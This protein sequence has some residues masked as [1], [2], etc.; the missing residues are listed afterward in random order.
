[1]D[2]WQS[3]IFPNLRF[4]EQ[5]TCE[6]NRKSY[7]FMKVLQTA[8]LYYFQ[9]VCLLVGVTSHSY[10]TLYIVILITRL[11]LQSFNSNKIWEIK[12]FGGRWKELF[13]NLRE[14]VGITNIKF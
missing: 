2:A 5:N 13:L 1:M 7:L 10:N 6:I 4:V 8:L 3:W 12:D 14:I 9:L 11:S